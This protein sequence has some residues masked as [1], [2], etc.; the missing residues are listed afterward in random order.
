MRMIKNY[1]PITLLRAVFK[2]WERLLATTLN[3]YTRNQPT[4]PDVNGVTAGVSP[5]DVPRT[6]KN[7]RKSRTSSI[8]H[9]NRLNKAYNRVN[10][11]LLWT[12][13][14]RMGFPALL[15]KALISTYSVCEEMI[16]IE[17]TVFTAYLLANGLC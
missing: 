8:L 14:H 5:N 4:S 3:K 11:K 16:M 1:R 7:V 6:A 13:L 2:V 12:I 10:R 15:V 9:V 17:G